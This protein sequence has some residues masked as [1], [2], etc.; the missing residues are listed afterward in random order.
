MVEVAIDAKNN[1]VT[2][3]GDI[4][5]TKVVKNLAKVGKMSDILSIAPY[6]QE[7]PKSKPKEESKPKAEVKPKEEAKSKEEPKKHKEEE[8]PKPRPKEENKAESLNPKFSIEIIPHC[9]GYYG[10]SCSSCCHVG[11]VSYGAGLPGYQ[12]QQ[13]G[14]REDCC[15][16]GYHYHG[17]GGGCYNDNVVFE[18]DNSCI[19]M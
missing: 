12:G 5:V 1:T 7:L 2:L 15:G 19:I 3:I 13:S 4:D 8:S 9:N 17:H 10:G 18:E 11:Q 14:S 6:N 16:A